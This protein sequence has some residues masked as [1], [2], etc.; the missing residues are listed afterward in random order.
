VLVQETPGRGGPEPAALTGS[1]GGGQAFSASTGEDMWSQE[2]R[3]EAIALHMELRGVV[4]SAKS[5]DNP[6]HICVFGLMGHG[7]SRLINLMLAAVATPPAARPPPGHAADAHPSAD[8]PAHAAA[9]PGSGWVEPLVVRQ[10]VASG[11]GA[12]TR[13]YS[14]H[15]LPAHTSGARGVARFPFFLVDTIGVKF[16]DEFDPAPV[17]APRSLSPRSS[18]LKLLSMDVSLCLPI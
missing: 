16:A 15:L 18:F 1:R 4:D 8:A 9:A 10:E 12:T 13:A 5:R 11:S 14:R 2:A 17:R 7:K 3:E 6:C